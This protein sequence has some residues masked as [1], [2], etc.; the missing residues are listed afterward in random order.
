MHALV[1]GVTPWWVEPLAR[2]CDHDLGLLLRHRGCYLEWVNGHTLSSVVSLIDAH[3]A[4]SKFKH[5]VAKADDDKLSV[6]CSF[7][8]ERARCRSKFKSSAHRA[9]T[10]S[11]QSH[12][13]TIFDMIIQN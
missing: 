12:V 4:I 2:S 1:G 11:Q 10:A 6:L 3:Q 9:S 5:V 8:K 13:C 7:L